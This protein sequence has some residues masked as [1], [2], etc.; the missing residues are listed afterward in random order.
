[1]KHNELVQKML[2]IVDFLWIVPSAENLSLS[3]WRNDFTFLELKQNFRNTREIVKTT[4]SYAEEENYA[5]YK[6]IVMP[7]ENF[8]AGC[9]PI[10]VNSFEDAMKEAR[11]RTRNGILV[12]SDRLYIDCNYL[13][14]MKEKW[15]VYHYFQNDFKANENP[16][17]FLQEGNVLI[18]DGRL[19]IGIE[20]TTVIVF[21]LRLA[22]EDENLH[23][24]N[25][26]MRCTT[27]LIV[28]K[29]HSF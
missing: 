19:T 6:G 15:K 17:K 28:V 5:Y 13:N 24:C 8:P 29:V 25:R 26:M 20:W 27:N 4:I 12:V 11:K 14:Q 23:N 16:Y 22:Y 3:I 18:V 7:P 2:E 21:G 1:M 9:P 10:V